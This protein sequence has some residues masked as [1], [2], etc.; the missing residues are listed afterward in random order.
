MGGFRL[1]TGMDRVKGKES[2]R[3]RER[4]G[5]RARQGRVLEEAEISLS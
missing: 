1:Q 5:E 2:D 3:G 4:R